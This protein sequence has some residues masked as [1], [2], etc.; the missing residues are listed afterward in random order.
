MEHVRVRHDDL[1]GAADGRPNRGRGVAV[2]GRRGDGEAGC[3]RE[4]AELGDLI[5]AERLGRKEEEG[6]SG[7]VVGDRLE[8]RQRVAQRLARRGRRDDDHVIAR[9]DRLDRVGL[10]AVQPVDAARRQAGPDPRI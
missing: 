5:L 7:R 6:A 4:L 3:P 10:V 2:I 8:D 1:A 9:P